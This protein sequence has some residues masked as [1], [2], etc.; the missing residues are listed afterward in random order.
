MRARPLLL[1]LVMIHPGR[2][3]AP[4]LAAVLASGCAVM[5]PAD[6]PR[7]AR[8]DLERFAGA[9]YV[10]AHIPPGMTADA[11]NGVERYRR[12][13]PDRIRIEYTYRDGGFDG[14]RERIRMKGRVLPDTGNAVWAVSPLWPLRFE[15]TVSYVGSD[16]DTAI[17]ARS[18]R[19]YVWIMARTPRIDDA[20][21]GDLVRRVEALGYDPEALRR[22]PQQPIAERED[23]G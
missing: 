14:E 8:V 3:I 22:M 7:A 15:N 10:I 20:T 21:Y 2:W 5:P 12:T 23:A 19:D 18:A 6:F 16:Y 4:F 9:W 13:G 11:H 17:V 1:E